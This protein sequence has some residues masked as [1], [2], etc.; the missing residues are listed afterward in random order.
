MDS[1]LQQVSAIAAENIYHIAHCVPD[2]DA[3]M[4][5]YGRRLQ[6][7]WATPFEVDDAMTTADGAA[8]DNRVRAV[9]SLQG[10]PFIELIEIVGRPGSLYDAP[11]GIHHLGV[12]AA[13]WRDEVARLVDA[14]MEVER[15]GSGLAFVRDPVLNVRY[16]IISFKGRDFL[17]DILSGKLGEQFPLRAK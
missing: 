6:I 14:G 9:Y 1:Q 10:P 13:R 12:Y 5:A 15:W 7:T 3:A 2:L 16:E 11:A 17:T 8:D 4:A